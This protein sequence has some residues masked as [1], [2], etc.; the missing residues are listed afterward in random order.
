M[1][2]SCQANLDTE[3]ACHHAE[4]W[5]CWGISSSACGLLGAWPFHS[6]PHMRLQV[7]AGTA[8]R[9]GALATS[10]VQTL[11][12]IAV[13]GQQPPPAVPGRLTAASSSSGTAPAAAQPA[14]QPA[15]TSPASPQQAPV[16]AEA[17]AGSAGN[18]SLPGPAP[19]MVSSLAPAAVFQ[20]VEWTLLL[21]GVA[22]T[23]TA[24]GETIKVWCTILVFTCTSSN[25]PQF[26]SRSRACYAAAAP[27]RHLF[28][29]AMH[30]CQ[31]LRVLPVQGDLMHDI[32]GYVGASQ[33]V[34]I[35]VVEDA[36]AQMAFNV[37]VAFTGSG[38]LTSQVC[39]P[40]S[41]LTHRSRICI[42]AAA[43]APCCRT[44][45]HPLPPSIVPTAA[46]CYST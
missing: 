23:D 39:S 20:T 33:P 12:R 19:G 15:L 36:S 7:L 34:N 41:D 42:C 6:C 29:I 1:A 9:F 26:Q 24:A 32:A 45:L 37:T 21:T 35:A 44:L 25:T 18:S 13:I 22:S 11:V 30:A 2:C 43:G 31:R 8:A 38:T 17:A 28:N 27:C 3:R 16:S 46:S 10:G 14:P 4:L 40:V 5:A